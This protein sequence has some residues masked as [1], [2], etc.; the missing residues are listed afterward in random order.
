MQPPTYV[1][2]H[3]SVH[4]T[5]IEDN[6]FVCNQSTKNF[7]IANNKLLLKQGHRNT[8]DHEKW[9][10]CVIHHVCQE[11]TV[12]MM[13]SCS[14]WWWRGV[15]L[16]GGVDGDAGGGMEEPS[17]VIPAAFPPS[18]LLRWQPAKFP[19]IKWWC[20]FQRDG[21]SIKFLIFIWQS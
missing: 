12:G 19:H 15:D 3:I 18:N 7:T 4:K 13:R 17:K 16:D 14:R 8:I 6:K 5:I 2:T 9:V 21:G 10:H 1:C 11:I 20:Y